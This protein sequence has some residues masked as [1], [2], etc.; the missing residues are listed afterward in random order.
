MVFHKYIIFFITCLVQL[1]TFCFSQQFTFRKNGNVSHIEFHYPKTIQESLSGK[2]SVNFAELFKIVSIEKDAPALPY[3]TTTLQLPETGTAEYLLTEEEHIVIHNIDVI[4][5]KG[6]HKPTIQHK[7]KAERGSVYQKNIFYPATTF[8]VSQPF[9]SRNTRGQF[10]RVNPFSYNP[11]TRE[12]KIYTRMIFTLHHRYDQQGYNEITTPHQSSL[13]L[14]EHRILNKYTDEKKY[15]PLREQG[16]LLV[17]Y[18]ES[19]KTVLQPLITWKNEKG[20]KTTGASLDTIGNTPEQIKTFISNYYNQHPDLLYLILAA[21]HDSIPAYYY[22]ESWGEEL[23]SDTYYGQL[24]GND[25]IPELMVGRLSGTKNEIETMVSRILEYEKNPLADR[26]MTNA[27]GIASNEGGAYG[28]NNEADYVHLRNIR[29]HLLNY[30]YHYVYEFYEGS[31]GDGDAP[32]NPSPAM[33]SDAINDGVGFI[34]YTGHGD[35]TLINTGSFTSSNVRALTNYGKYPFFV[36]VA[37]N[38]G[39]F[40][41]GNCLAEEFLRARKTEGITGAVAFCGSSILM[42]WAQPMRTQ[43]E[44]VSILTGRDNTEYKS[45]LGGLFYNGQLGMYE[46]YN[47]QDAKEVMQTWI[48][49]GDPTTEFRTYYPSS[50]DVIHV[51]SILH[52]ETS[53]QVQCDVEGATTA[54][55]INGSLLDVRTIVNSNS[56]HVFELPEGTDRI[57]LTVSKQNYLPYTK[58][59]KVVSENGLYTDQIEQNPIKVYPNP[60]SDKI[61]IQAGK[62]Q[63][64][65]IRLTDLSGKTILIQSP[66]TEKEKEELDLRNLARGIYQLIITT[67]NSTSVQKIILR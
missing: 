60:A 28:D 7:I 22:G 25:F 51:D 40:I 13:S 23:Y 42:A 37:C 9:I 49:F 4:P 38:N 50:L 8:E 64:N 30:G 55:S 6:N 67:N 52:T 34:N 63:M 19:N 14:I 47:D 20:I 16:E 53:L 57:L 48:F 44:I 54:L 36:S 39:K 18:P 33:I 15:T 5:S 2:E 17:I 62:E 41:Y 27:I 1:F 58:Y 11:V 31:Q 29:S 12:L 3:F 35:V 32:G 24:I 59:I 46:T 45:T 56:S 10:F 21:D 61:I 26:W 66:D 43:D 65:L